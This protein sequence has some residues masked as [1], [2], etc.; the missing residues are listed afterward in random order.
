MRNLEIGYNLP[1]RLANKLYMGE[2]RICVRGQNLWNITGFGGLEPEVG[3]S[4]RLGG[5]TGLDRDTAPQAASI[6]AGVSV[7]F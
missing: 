4:P 3:L 5:F 7:T 6:Q 2:A 1:K